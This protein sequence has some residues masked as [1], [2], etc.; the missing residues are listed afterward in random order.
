NPPPPCKQTSSF[1]TSDAYPV[2]PTRAAGCEP[3]MAT[4]KSKPYA[5]NGSHTSGI[6]AD[7]SIDGPVIGTL[8]AIVDRAKNLPNR[9]TIGKQDPYCAARLGKEAK[10][11][12]TD[13]R[14]GQTP[15]WDEELRFTVHD[16]PDYYQLK[17]SVFTDDR[18]TDLI[19]EAWVDLKGIVVAGGGQNDMWQTLSCR[20]KYAGEIRVEITYYDNRPKPDKPALKPRQPAGS[21]Q[22]ADSMS[23]RGPVKRRP[24][25]SDPVTGEAPLPPPPAPL[26]AEH[27]HQ[28][29][30][31]SHGKSASHSGFVPTQSP[32]QAVEYNTPP[33]PAAQQHPDHYSPSSQPRYSNARVDG[34]R[35]TQRSRESF[36]AALRLH[37]DRGYSQAAPASPYDQ[38]DPP[39]RSPLPEHRH[40]MPAGDDVW[41]L[42]QFED[43]PPPPPPAHRSRHNSGGQEL[44][45]R[46]SYDPPPQKSMPSLPMRHDVLKSE[47]HR[48]SAPSYPGRPTFRAYDSAPAASNA[49]VSYNPSSYE[50]SS[51]RFHSHDAAYDSQYRSMQP[52][53]EDVPESPPG[54]L[55]NPYRHGGSRMNSRDEMTFETN[56]STGPLNLG[57]S[58]GVSPPY[59]SGGSH[60]DRNGHPASA[61]QFPARDYADSP[62]YQPYNGQNH[63]PS[64]RHEPGPNNNRALQAYGLPEVP[65]SLCPGLDSGL[66]Y[67]ISEQIYEERRRDR[68]PPAA[69]PTRG[70]HISEGPPSYGASPQGYAPHSR[71]GRSAITYSGGPDNQLVR[72]RNVSPNPNPQHAIRRKSVSPAPPPAD[73]RR[74]SDI[75]FSP[76]SYDALNPSMATPRDSNLGS[77]RAHP[78][79]KIMTHDGR[80]IDPSDHL[81]MESWAP[82]PEPKPEQKQA[83][84]EPRARPSPSGAQPMP[85]S[86]RRP[87]RVAGRPQSSTGPPPSFHNYGEDLRTPPAPVSTGRNRLQKK[88]NRASAGP[89]PAMSSPLAPV[90]TDNYQDRQSPYTPTR[91]H[92]LRRAGS[93]DYPSEN[94]APHHGSGPPIPAKVPLMSGANGGVDYALMEEMQ[95]IDIGA[96]RSRRRGGY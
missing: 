91:G 53:V 78:D 96:G 8:V 50:S 79:D 36:D 63:R 17:I 11:T 43:G 45:H 66:S 37:E 32:L 95:R 14:G 59:I 60:Q 77:E 94:H 85:P 81:P 58:P 10:K 33:P 57:H 70:R 13:V 89:S 19:G 72:H 20:G 24:L 39:R 38:P 55:A 28:T 67:E 68:Y 76:D 41:Q 27:H 61:P 6:F 1:I 49:R 73:N 93:W 15:K 82:E 62:S 47:A 3:T 5:L 56:P 74:V 42:L 2:A 26:P 18:K 31:R 92:G 29:P 69:T 75:P 71:D 23:Q 51:T 34:P 22:D 35:Q 88:A 83:S 9:K 84:P 52:T 25:P 64:P 4:A 87:L 65:A 54:P 16:S 12:T 90:S 40:E 48:H 80:E 46:S 30:P 44:V 86:G 7:M 21:E